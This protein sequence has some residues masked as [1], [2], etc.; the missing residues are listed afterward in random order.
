MGAKQVPR[1]RRKFLDANDDHDRKEGLDL[2]PSRFSSGMKPAKIADA[3]QSGWEHVL[4]VA[5]HEL[6]GRERA[7][8][9]EAVF[10]PSVSE[11][12]RLRGGGQNAF[13]ADRCAADVASEV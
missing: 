1:E 6:V 11:A 4:Q 2:E 12:H 10:G 8:V 5:A 7:F 13:V 3:V 9:T